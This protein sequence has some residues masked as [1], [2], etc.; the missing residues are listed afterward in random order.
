MSHSSDGTLLIVQHGPGRG[1]L[2]DFRRHVLEWLEAEAPGLW[3]RIRLH[4]TGGPPPRLEGVRAVVFWLAD[5]LREL[6]QADYAEAVVIADAVRASGGTLV[7]PPE[8]LSNS[9]K[10]VQSRLWREAGIPCAE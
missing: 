2:Y 4:E 7:N 5:P 3:P 6:Y 9:I 8:A 1:R 10:S